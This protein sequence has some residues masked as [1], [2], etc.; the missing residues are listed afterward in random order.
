[1][2]WLLQIKR[3]LLMA[4]ILSNIFR[5]IN[6]NLCSLKNN[7]IENTYNDIYLD[8]LELRKWN[9]NSCQ[10][11]FLKFSREVHKIKFKTKFFNKEHT[12][13]FYID[14][15][16]YLESNNCLKHILSKSVLKLYVLLLISMITRVNPLIIWMKKQVYESTP[17]T[18]ILKN[19]LRNTLKYF[20]VLK[21]L[22]K[23]S[24]DPSLCSQFTYVYAYAYFYGYICI[25]LYFWVN[26]MFHVHMLQCICV[27]EWY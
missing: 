17:I 10:T 8:V 24:L 9:K 2:E 4:W 27:Y 21:I 15:M 20:K 3:D 25:C 23:N 14:S 6:D 12:F 13:Q 22:L 19:I 5:I 1:M 18:A 16:V 26:L 7:K 11:S